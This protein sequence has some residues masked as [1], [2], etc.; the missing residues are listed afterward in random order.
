MAEVKAIWAEVMPQVRDA[1]TGVGVWTALNKA[2]A[3]ALDEDTLVLGIPHE[4]SDLAGHLRMQQT[5]TVIERMVGEHLKVKVQLRVIDGITRE[6]WEQVKRRDAEARRLQEIA[7]TKQRAENAARSS[8][9]T[10]YEQISRRYAA[11][12]NKSLPQNRAEFFKEC[13]DVLVEGLRVMPIQD[14]LAER[15]FARCIE[16]VATY[17]EVPSTL[18]AFHLNDRMGN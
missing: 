12:E 13:L 6:D 11:I 16:R 1:V 17:T 5:K 18:V 15:N 8:W 2:Q 14:E 7:L 3:V 10:I 4:V 9:D